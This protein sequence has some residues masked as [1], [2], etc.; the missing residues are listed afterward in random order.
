MFG[1]L[2][3]FLIV[4]VG[5]GTVIARFPGVVMRLAV[6]ASATVVLTV[7]AYVFVQVNWG[8]QQGL[9]EVAFLEQAPEDCSS[10]LALEIDNRSNRELSF[11]SGD[12][13]G[14]E[15]GFSR[16][17]IQP[18]AYNDLA[19][20]TDMIVAA[21]S[22]AILCVE[23]LPWTLVKDSSMSERVYADP[24]AFQWTLTNRRACLASIMIEDLLG[25]AEACE[26]G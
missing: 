9:V 10:G 12:V 11:L 5:V 25:V 14:Y 6:G 15:P 2:M 21:K 26:A 16:P 18:P 8:R 13:L 7:A 23:R 20:E 1:I 17:K 22:T 19:L 4:A 3:T 24:A